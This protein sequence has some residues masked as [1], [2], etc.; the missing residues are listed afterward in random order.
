ME[1]RLARGE[2]PTI[3]IPETPVHMKSASKAATMPKAEP[4]GPPVILLKKQPK[5]LDAAE[6]KARKASAEEARKSRL[7]PVSPVP[8]QQVSPQT[9]TKGSQ[10]QTTPVHPQKVVQKP[11]LQQQVAQAISAVKAKVATS[12][13]HQPHTSKHVDSLPRKTSMKTVKAPE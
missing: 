7:T 4:Q 12:I 5:R 1:Q 6:I 13:S 8:A 2:L 9:P 11:G 3:P 10:Q